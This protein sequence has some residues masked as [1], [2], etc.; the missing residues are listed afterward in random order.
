MEYQE[1]KIIKRRQG[2]NSSSKKDI[3]NTMSKKV[4]DGKKQ[5]LEKS[6]NKK[7]S[8]EKSENKYESKSK[9]KSKSKLT[10]NSS[11]DNIY[12]RGLVKSRM[13][14]ERRNKKKV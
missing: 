7:N 4:R 6:R 5:S 12:L 8:P 10:K 2:A 3:N 1:Q 9:S 13:L 14:E 11:S